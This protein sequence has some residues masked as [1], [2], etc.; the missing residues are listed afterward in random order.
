MTARLSLSSF[1]GANGC[2][3]DLDASLILMG[4]RYY[5]PRI[6]RFISQDPAGSRDNW[7]AYAGNNPINKTD[8]SG[9][10]PMMSFPEGSSA[11]NSPG[12]L[13][14]NSA[15]AGEWAMA[16]AESVAPN[17]QINQAF[18]DQNASTARAA[19]DWYMNGMG[20]TSDA[21]N[22]FL[23]AGTASNLGKVTGNYDSGKASGLEV[24]FAGGKALGMALLVA[25]P[26]G[27][28]AAGGCNVK[29]NRRLVG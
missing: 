20:G 10:M 5:D 2:Q 27:K 7:Y 4:H 8:P 1:G 19:E 17:Q 14:V 28:W 9:L 25:T 29:D 11:A 15:G 24:T 23:M 21:V 26:A 6:G 3:T 13:E 18:S 16:F 22:K 12:Y